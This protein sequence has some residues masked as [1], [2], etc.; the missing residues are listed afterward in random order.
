M[1]SFETSDVTAGKSK[2]FNRCTERI[3]LE[4]GAISWWTRSL[5]VGTATRQAAGTTVLCSD[6]M[7]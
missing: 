3:S 2:S 4:V 6:L 5:L 7:L 1:R